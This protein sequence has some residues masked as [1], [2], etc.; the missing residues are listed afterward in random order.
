MAPLPPQPNPNP[1]PLP[2]PDPALT[3]TP[4]P[5][6]V[7]W[8]ITS[9]TKDVPTLLA[10]TRIPGHGGALPATHPCNRS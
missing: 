6:Q 3:V 2:Q 9:P 8:L 5:N 1:Q 7:E 10:N 4:T